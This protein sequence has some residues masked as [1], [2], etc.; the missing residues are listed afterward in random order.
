MS[1]KRKSTGNPSTNAPKR[2]KK[3][4]LA[5]PAK[6]F[7]SRSSSTPFQFKAKAACSRL[8]TWNVN[9][10]MSVDEK[11]LKKYLDEENPDVLILTETEY[12]KEGK[13]NIMSL[14]THFKYQHWSPGP[15]PGYAGTAI[16]SKSKPMKTT[17]GLP[18]W[19]SES[20]GRYVE[21]EFENVFIIG[22]YV[23]HAVTTSRYKKFVIQKHLE[24]LDPSKPVIWGGDFN[25]I[26]SKQALPGSTGT[27]CL[28]SGVKSI[29]R[30]KNTHTRA[31]NMV[32]GN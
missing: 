1:L 4:F 26:M 3:D 32:H 24:Q 21:L 27:R 2:P 17:I 8:T 14:K 7:T 5:R 18:S 22:A 28:M 10:I 11:T 30:K 31:R 19:E 9:G 23:P 29:P 12:S 15:R 13:P 25:C 16:L 20:K 6:N